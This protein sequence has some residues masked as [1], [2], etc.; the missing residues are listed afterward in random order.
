MGALIARLPPNVGVNHVRG[1]GL[2]HGNVIKTVH[3]M[4]CET[5]LTT[6]SMACLCMRDKTILSRGQ[7][8]V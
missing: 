1:S 6:L 5:V 2:S 8:S 3:D 7:Y 4:C